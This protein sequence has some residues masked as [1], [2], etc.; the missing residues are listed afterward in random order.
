MTDFPFDTLAERLQCASKKPYSTQSTGLLGIHEGAS[1]M[2][3]AEVEALNYVAGEWHRSR[4]SDFMEIFNPA[5]TE[6]LARVPLAGRD[7]VAEAVSAASRAFPAWRRTPPQNRIQ[8]LFK[9]KQLLEGHSEEIAR[10][11]TE[12]NGKTLVESRAELQ[13]GI[14]NVEVACGIPTLMQGYNLE[15]ASTG[16]D[17]IMIR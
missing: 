4:S 13:R 12:E 10:L 15:D 2:A 7:D 5:T 17:E 11:I 16:I 8:Y 1:Q 14:E 3:V 9:F 6:L